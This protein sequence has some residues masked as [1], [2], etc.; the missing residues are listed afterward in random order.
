MD[1]F[2]FGLRYWKKYIPLS[3]LSKLFSLLAM[4]CDLAIPLISAGF[5]D[6]LINFD[7]ADPPEVPHPFSSCREMMEICAREKLT[8]AGLVLLNECALRPSP[9]V[10]HGV[11]DEFGYSGPATELLKEFGLCASHIEEVVKKAL[12]K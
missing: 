6:Y 8:I 12:G 5:I 1:V 3:L 2:R 4:V 10:R 7:P 9:V 11:N